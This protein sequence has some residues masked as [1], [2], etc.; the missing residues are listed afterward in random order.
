MSTKYIKHL[1][2]D[3]MSLE[4]IYAF[5]IIDTMRYN[6]NTA[7]ES[8]T[9]DKTI[10]FL[11][12]AKKKAVDGG[13][14]NVSVSAYFES[15]MYDDTSYG[16]ADIRVTGYALETDIQYK[17]RLNSI[18]NRMLISK[19]NFEKNKAYYDA[20][21]DAERISEI[22]KVIEKLDTEMKFEI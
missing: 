19:K 14:V 3:S 16:Y 15:E 5:K 13:Y 17:T 22:E 20:G 2:T 10:E 9:I 12:N 8:N 21:G 11:T 6:D 7:H 1:N 18:K 4:K